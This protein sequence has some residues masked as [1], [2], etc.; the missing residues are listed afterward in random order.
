VIVAAWHG[1]GGVGAAV[2][3]QLPPSVTQTVAGL[4]PLVTVF[5]PSLRVYSPSGMSVALVAP[6][7]AESA[8]LAP[9]VPPAS[10]AVMTDA[11]GPLAVKL[12]S[13]NCR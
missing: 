3:R 8:Y 11:P 7:R 9:T 4:P 2:A 13:Y 6:E 12:K 5:A 10:V 1:L